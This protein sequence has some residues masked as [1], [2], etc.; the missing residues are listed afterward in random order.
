MGYERAL[1]DLSCTLHSYIFSFFLCWSSYFSVSNSFYGRA[2]PRGFIMASLHLKYIVAL[3]SLLKFVTRR[4]TDDINGVHIQ[5]QTGQV[6][7]NSSMHWVRERLVTFMAVFQKCCIVNLAISQ[8]LKFCICSV[9]C[10][11]P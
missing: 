1:S 4:C 5:K 3:T 8:H 6:W 10:F 7:I 9:S 2:K 11:W